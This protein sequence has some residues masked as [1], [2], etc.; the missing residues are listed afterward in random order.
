M[1]ELNKYIVKDTSN[2]RTAIKTMDRGGIGFIV[3]V[4]KDEKVIGIVTDGDFRRALLKGKTLIENVLSIT[5]NKFKYLEKGYTEDEAKFY[6]KDKIVEYL[7]ILEKGK[8]VDI[9]SKEELEGRV[10]FELSNKKKLNLPVVIMAGGRGTRLDPVTRVLP[11]ALIPIGEK[12]IIEIIMD[13]YSK[14]GMNHF[15]ISVSHK[16]KIIKAYFNGFESGYQIEYIN[17]SKPLGTAGALRYLLGRI[18]K[19]FFTSNCDVFIKNDYSS[20]VQFHQ[21]G[22]FDLTLVGC[23]KHQRIPYGVCTFKNG[24]LLKRIEEKPEYDFLVNTGMYLMNPAILN[25]VP[26]KKYFD[27]I[28]LIALIQKKDRKVGVYPVSE[29]SWLDIGQWEEYNSTV[30]KLAK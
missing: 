13:E 29:K 15:Y 24:G 10:D 7:P 17:E 25:Y 20:I 30:R 26:D 22:K 9:I 5:N 18:N 2:I 11:K 12:P 28:D 19:P 14:Y 3:I 21:D 1:K 8:L 27:M 23:M 16:E 6:F 4:D